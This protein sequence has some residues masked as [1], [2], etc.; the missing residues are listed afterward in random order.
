MADDRPRI[1]SMGEYYEDLL[2]VDAAINDRTEASQATS[3]LYAKLQEREVK[4]IQ[5]VKYL[6]AKRGISFEA[7]WLQILKGKYKKITKEELDAMNAIDPW[8]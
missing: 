4:I 2:T 1:S 8:L 5:R 7:M 3:L 6:A